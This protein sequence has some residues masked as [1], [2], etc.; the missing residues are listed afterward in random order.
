MVVVTINYRLGPL[1]FLYLGHLTDDTLYQESGNLG[2]WDQVAALT[3]V[4]ENIAAFGGDPDRVTVAGQSAGSV[5]VGALLTMPAAGGLFRRA[6]M[7]SGAERPKTAAEAHRM[8]LRLLEPLGL[9]PD[10]WRNLVMAPVEDLVAGWRAVMAESGGHP[11]APVADGVSLPT[12]YWD[13]LA[14]GGSPRRT[15]LDRHD[16]RRIRPVGRHGTDVAYG[17]GR[18]NGCPS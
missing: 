10:Q 17:V 5:S 4:R 12:G 8:T 6:I 11:W 3:W 18:N 14:E 2:L 16:A 13:A 15:A 9:P 1:G 7:E